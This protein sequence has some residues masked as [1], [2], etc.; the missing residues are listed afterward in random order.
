MLGLVSFWVS[1]GRLTTSAT[2]L[3]IAKRAKRIVLLSLFSKSGCA[4]PAWERESCTTCCIVSLTGG[5]KSGE[6]GYLKSWENV[7]C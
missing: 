2:E 4:S 5:S 7:A 1:V 3:L 6:T